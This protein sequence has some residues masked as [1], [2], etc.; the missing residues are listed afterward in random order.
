MKLVAVI[1]LDG[2]LR[3]ARGRPRHTV[4]CPALRQVKK[5]R[6]H[7]SQHTEKYFAHLSLSK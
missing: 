2:K 3:V 5:L 7:R 6:N 4:N 1:D